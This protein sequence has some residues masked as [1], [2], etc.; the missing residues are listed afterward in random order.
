MINQRQENN[1]KIQLKGETNITVKI[2]VQNG[3]VEDLMRKYDHRVILG[4]RGE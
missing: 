4:W 1:K 3:S 2:S